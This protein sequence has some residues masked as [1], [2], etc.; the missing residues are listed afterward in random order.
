MTKEM[1][2]LTEW[3]FGLML[4]IG[5]LKVEI[6]KLKTENEQLKERLADY[7]ELLKR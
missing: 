6:T 7:K 5:D 2:E 4:S 1:E 3:V